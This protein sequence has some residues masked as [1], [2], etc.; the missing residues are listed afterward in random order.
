MK[1]RMNI[2]YLNKN[3]EG[4]R[5]VALKHFK[6]IYK[7]FLEKIND[8]IADVEFDMKESQR[9]SKEE[10]EDSK[11]YEGHWVGMDAVRVDYLYLL[12]KELEKELEK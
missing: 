3:M 11:Y 8:M 1:K 7:E 6:A 5:Q 2:L 9:L 4:V 10:N 12:K